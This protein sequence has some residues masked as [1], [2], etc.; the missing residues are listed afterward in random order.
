MGHIQ[1]VSSCQTSQLSSC[2][3]KVRSSSKCSRGVK[4]WPQF[5][6]SAATVTFPSWCHSQLDSRA[7][8]PA[9]QHTRT[10][11]V[12]RSFIVYSITASHTLI[13]KTNHRLY[14]RNLY[15]RLANSSAASQQ[16]SPCKCACAH[17]MC[18]LQVLGVC[19]VQCTV[20]CWCYYCDILYIY[21]NIYI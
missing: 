6:H 10:R 18:L 4:V 17:C 1:C 16:D 2:Y 9:A 21:V 13:V 14:N 8:V 3:E 12:M 20:Y 19:A 5:W 11:S 15:S 7:Q